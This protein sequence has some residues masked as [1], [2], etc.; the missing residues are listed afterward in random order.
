V[1]PE[2]WRQIN[3]V[4]HAA[5]EREP[6]VRDRFLDTIAE[7]DADLAVEV[8]SL[9]ARHAAAGG[10]LE[11]PAWGVAPELVLDD[12][13]ASLAGRLIGPY[14][15]EE[16][17]G[18]GGMGV[19][20]AAEDTRLRRPVALKALPPEYARDPSRRERLMR[21]ARTAAALSHPAV[22][23]V[24][25]LED[26]D[27]ELY[28]ASE[29]VRGRTLREELADG[30]L[31]PARLLETLTDIASGLAAA[32]ALQIVHRDLKPENIVRR[33][34]GQIKILD[35]G[36][37]R[38]HGT[39]ARTT[40]RLT[41]TG[42]A[43]GTPGYMA[44][45]QF[46]GGDVDSRA[47][48]FA[49]GILGWELAT[50]RH[51]LGA[52]GAEALAPMKDLVD[53][54]GTF[55]AGLPVH[56]LAPVL[57][58]CVRLDPAERYR[59]AEPLLLDLRRARSASHDSAPAT[60]EEPSSGMWWWQF[61]QA[62]VAVINGLS[63]IV[64]WFVRQWAPRY[65]LLLF[66]GVLALATL[67]VSLRLNLLFTAKVHP[68][69]LR[70]HRARHYPW[71]AGAEG[72][73]ALLLLVSAALVAGPRDAIAAVLVTLAISTIASLGIIE[74]A[75]TAAAGLKLDLPTE[76]GSSA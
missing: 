46:S 57:R 64:V 54:R 45:E 19:V 31:P 18:R 29:L 12:G 65:G 51:P 70:A 58:R 35:F 66:Y 53:G 7:R 48:V 47:D 39:D 76:R 41:Q 56:G 9:L 44:P 27:G 37:A 40:V 1:T 15:V 14:Q 63:P 61:H 62:A 21:E 25:A 36:L 71:M 75:T 2:R 42:M 32:H 20:Y 6:A 13:Q 74:P 4:F 16:E 8:R 10:F 49:F 50:G 34:D 5:L 11:T 33:H 68:S 67:S 17:I 43:L 69:M 26:I 72:A 73:L 23:T 60:P 52:D 3:D 28:L 55:A 24:F 30:P 38:S 59:S 22:A